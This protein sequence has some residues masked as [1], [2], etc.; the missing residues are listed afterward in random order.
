MKAILKYI[1][2]V[3]MVAAALALMW[4]I[5]CLPMILIDPDTKLGFSLCSFAAIFIFLLEFCLVIIWLSTYA[6][7]VKLIPEDDDSK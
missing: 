2:G 5:A 6:T 1:G 3:L 7:R 4:V